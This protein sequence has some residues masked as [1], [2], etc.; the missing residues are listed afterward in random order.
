MIRRNSSTVTIDI[1]MVSTDRNAAAVNGRPDPSVVNLRST[2]LA[3]QA[4]VYAICVYMFIDIFRIDC[5]YMYIYIYT[6]MFFICAHTHIGTPIHTCITATPS[7]Y[8]HACAFTYYIYIMYI[9]I[10]IY[11]CIYIYNIFIFI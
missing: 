10:Y 7:V 4:F 6:Q 8:M 1:G 9:Y 11:I 3:A 5:R 2:S